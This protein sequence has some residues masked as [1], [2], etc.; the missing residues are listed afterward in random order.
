MTD[1]MLVLDGDWLNQD[2]CD[3]R[4]VQLVQ[5]PNAK[6]AVIHD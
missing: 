2:G 4:Q 5:R 6:D 1:C 3:G